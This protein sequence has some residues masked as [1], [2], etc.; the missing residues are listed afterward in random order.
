MSSWEK[1]VN[2]N[3]YFSSVLQI[4]IFYGKFVL[5]FIFYPS[6]VDIGHF[7]KVESINQI[8]SPKC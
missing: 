8:S 7:V 4:A 5:L 2:Q 6:M 1:F 3:I